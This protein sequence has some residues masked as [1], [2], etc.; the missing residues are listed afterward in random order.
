MSFLKNILVVSAF[1]SLS[2]AQYYSVGDVV[3]ASHQNQ[4][5][6]VCS[7]GEGYST[8]STLKLGDFNGATNGGDYHVIGI[9]MSASW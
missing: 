9:D 8:N 7:G 2:I 3:N 5:V 1:F 4:G 6:S